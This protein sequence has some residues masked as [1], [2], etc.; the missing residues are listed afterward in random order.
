MNEPIFL[1]HIFKD[2]HFRQATDWVEKLES[3]ESLGN[4][5]VWP[6]MYKTYTIT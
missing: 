6:L 4:L 1:G 5:L 2:L 3:I